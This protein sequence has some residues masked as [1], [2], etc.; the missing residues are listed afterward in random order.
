MHNV[1]PQEEHRW[2]Q[3]LVGEWA[4]ETEMSMGPDQPVMKT[5]GT[6]SVRSLG[7]LWT[8]SETV[9]P[10]PDGE[11]CRSI[12]TLGYDPERKRF[13]GTFVASVMTKLWIYDGQLDATGKVLTLDA[14]GPSMTG[15]GTTAKY[16]DV[17]EFKSADERLFYSRVQDKSGAWNQFMMATYRRQKP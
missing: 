7:G 16:Q 9:G 3:Q 11:E 4:F 12:I 13:V 14:E 10:M 6:E 8:L 2:L 5:A 17:I 1:E 15:D